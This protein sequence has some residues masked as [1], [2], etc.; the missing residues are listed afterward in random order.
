LRRQAAAPALLPVRDAREQWR[1]AGHD[2][3]LQRVCPRTGL[4]LVDGRGGRC[5]MARDEWELYRGLCHAAHEP[6]DRAL[7]GAVKTDAAARRGSTTEG[8]AA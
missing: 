4:Y 3:A 8:G 6:V 2:S 1:A 5:L 7:A